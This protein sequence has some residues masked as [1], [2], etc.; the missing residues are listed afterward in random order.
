MKTDFID[1]LEQFQS[2]LEKELK[3]IE[4]GNGDKES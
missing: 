1:E 2:N 3:E 4:D